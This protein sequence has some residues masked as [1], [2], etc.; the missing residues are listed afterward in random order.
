MVQPAL[1]LAAALFADAA[2]VETPVE[3]PSGWVQGSRTS[4]D[5]V[6][7]LTFAVKQ[8]GK[9]E[10]H[11]ALMRVSMPS[12][13]DYGQ[14]LSNEEVHQMTAPDT[15][16]VEAVMSFIRAH[17]G[18]PVAA[19]PNSD[20]ITAKVTVETAE[21]MLSAKYH[22]HVHASGKEISRVADGYS[23]PDEVALAVDFVSPTVHFPGVRRPTQSQELGAESSYNTPKELRQLYNVDVEGKAT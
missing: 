17:G 1:I 13:P 15:A 6:I 18:E 20:M 4:Q 14:H 22:Q 12:S 19:T 10:L 3:K 23:L 21:R 7:E 2:S 11:D 9:Q 16:H 8:Q 5:Q